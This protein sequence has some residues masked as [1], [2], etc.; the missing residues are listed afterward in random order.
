ML[1]HRFALGATSSG[2]LST[3]SL[4]CPCRWQRPSQRRT[5]QP[6]QPGRWASRRAAR[7]PQTGTC[8]TPHLPPPGWR[9]AP[10]AR[11]RSAA[12]LVW[13]WAAGTQWGRAT[14]WRSAATWPCGC[15]PVCL[16]LC[17]A[18]VRARNLVALALHALQQ[19]CCSRHFVQTCKAEAQKLWFLLPGF[20]PLADAHPA[21][22]LSRLCR[23]MPAMWCEK[24][25]RPWQRRRSSTKPADRGP[26]PRQVCTVGGLLWVGWAGLWYSCVPAPLPW[27]HRSFNPQA[28]ATAC[29]VVNV[30]HRC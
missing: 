13:A 16:M 19:R 17:V 3:A 5:R 12:H 27:L 28:C 20:Q 1:H 21:C 24:C 7:Q 14:P 15:E 30:L 22:E 11:T 2:G 10:Q 25:T 26:T 18:G 9:A 4:A 29:T 6:T 8:S 23:R